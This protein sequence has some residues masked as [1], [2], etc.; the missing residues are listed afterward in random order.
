MNNYNIDN[1]LF[2]LKSYIIKILNEKAINF[3]YLE[4]ET[5]KTIESYKKLI[6]SNKKFY[7][8]ND[9]LRE[10]DQKIIISTMNN[11]ILNLWIPFHYWLSPECLVLN[12]IINNFELE[13]TN[14]LKSYI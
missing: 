13:I 1:L 3:Y 9:E 8:K 11:K 4:T 7:E 10:N 5:L 6:D 12:D 2:C 14:H